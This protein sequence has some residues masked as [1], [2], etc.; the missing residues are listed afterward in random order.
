MTHVSRFT[1]HIRTSNDQ[2]AS[3]WIKFDRV[4]DKR[5]IHYS[6]YHRV[7]T[8]LDVNARFLNQRWA[9]IFQVF[10]ALCEVL[11]HIQLSNGSRQ[12]LQLLKM[13]HQQIEQLFPQLFF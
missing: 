4:G 2:H 12:L 7:A 6:L 11:Q 10:C 3:L 8:T 1:A 13:R 5:L 9:T